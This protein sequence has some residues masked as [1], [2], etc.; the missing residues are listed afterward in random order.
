M[1]WDENTA[2]PNNAAYVLRFCGWGGGA[3]EGGGGK[4][5][6]DSTII[7]KGTHSSG[8]FFIW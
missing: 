2:H 7:I 3:E 5:Q 1:L 8:I 6:E 4:L